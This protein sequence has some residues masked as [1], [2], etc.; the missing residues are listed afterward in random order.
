MK[1]Y[2]WKSS[3]TRDLV[4]MKSIA[5]GGEGKTGYIIEAET[6]TAIKYINK[7]MSS[8][9]HDGLNSKWISV[10]QAEENVLFFDSKSVFLK[11]MN[12]LLNTNFILDDHV[13]YETYLLVGAK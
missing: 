4:A 6:T 1:F 11:F 2:N 7:I 13:G 8:I 9:Q 5:V 3:Q 12:V 10:D